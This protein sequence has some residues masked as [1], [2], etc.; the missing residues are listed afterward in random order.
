V[1]FCKILFGIWCKE[2]KDT[3]NKVNVHHCKVIKRFWP[4][5]NIWKNKNPIYYVLTQRYS[6]KSPNMVLSNNEWHFSITELQISLN[7]AHGT[8]WG[9]VNGVI[10]LIRKHRCHN[11]YT[12]SIFGN[13]DSKL[14]NRIE[15]WNYILWYGD[16]N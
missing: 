11:D 1:H 7:K 15:I 2:I 16:E 8:T 13:R 14:W 10:A 3:N 6:L 12:N 4:K 5:R 9:C